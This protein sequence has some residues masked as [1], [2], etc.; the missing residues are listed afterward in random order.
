MNGLWAYQALAAWLTLP[1]ASLAPLGGRW[2][3]RL[4]EGFPHFL[5]RLPR[6]PATPGTEDQGRVWVHGVS[7]GESLV[8][9][10]VLAGLKA[11]RPGCRVGFTTTHP[12]VIGMAR[13]RSEPSA[14]A[15]FPLDLLPVMERA[16][17]RWRPDLV[18]IVETDFWP[19][20]AE[21]CR[22]HGI[23]LALVNGRI[24]EKHQRFWSMV[25]AA[26]RAMF[27]SF[28]H[29]GVQTPTDRLRLVRMGA[30]PEKI[31][32]LGNIKVETSLGSGS[33]PAPPL[34]EWAAGC[35]VLV[36]G[37]LH[38]FEFSALLPEI[39]RLVKD[40]RVRVIVAPRKISLAEAWSRDLAAQG[41]HVSL[42]TR[43]R[44]G[45]PDCGFSGNDCQILVLDTMG[46]L[47]GLYALA[48][49]AVIGGTLDPAVG[50]H[51]PLEALKMGVPVIM[52]AWHRNFQDLVN[53]LVPTG[54]VRVVET[55]AGVGAAVQEELT[56]PLPVRTERLAAA[57]QVL[58]RHAGALEA[59]LDAIETLLDHP[60][61][62][63]ASRP[64]RRG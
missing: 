1:C 58:S 51:N 38:P 28:A 31:H 21:V 29:F 14:V 10:A 48:R 16:M 37:S 54:G 9:F 41:L 42:R 19:G 55:A 57:R 35:A 6:W 2:S 64:S 27:A 32:V 25:P 4:A 22:R 46:E 17:A 60:T 39:V 33:S 3:R 30:D 44:E 7:V 18:V 49:V 63:D 26:A 61:W 15:Y 52:G 53:E 11:R 56:V 8:A 50:G 20:M 43:F 13:R 24:S 62:R 36:F 45:E 34:A 40:P 12:D 5:G 23:P 47:A 59:T